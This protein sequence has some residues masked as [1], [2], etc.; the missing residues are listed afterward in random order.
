MGVEANLTWSTF[1]CKRP[2]RHRL[3]DILGV[4]MLEPFTL[5]I[6][7]GSSVRNIIT[8]LA[9]WMV[10][11]VIGCQEQ[12]NPV[13]LPISEQEQ[14]DPEQPPRLPAPVL[15]VSPPSISPLVG[16]KDI[17][18]DD[19]ALLQNL[20]QRHAREGTLPQAVQYQYWVVQ[21]TEQGR[22]DLACWESLSGKSEAAL[23]WLQQAG[24]REGIDTRWAQVDADLE[25]A[26]RDQ[27]WPKLLAYLQRCEKY[28][29][30]V[31][32]KETVLV[33]PK[34]Y[35]G[36]TILPTVLWLHGMGGDPKDMKILF[37][38]LADQHQI[39]FI[40]VSGTIPTG[41][42]RFAWAD[43]VEEDYDQIQQALIEAQRQIRMRPGSVVALGFSQGA[44]V[45][46]E[47]AVRH[48]EI[49]AGAITVSA[50][51]GSPVQLDAVSD[52][53]D[54]IRQGFVI[55]CGSKENEW[56]VRRSNDV[57]EW[58]KNGNAKVLKPDYP[59]HS[60]HSFPEDFDNRLPEWLAFVQK[61]HETSTP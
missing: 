43:V 42:H 31:V 4:M 13:P 29:R 7:S 6:L 33:V 14:D 57:A 38:P 46:I 27:R 52:T 11:F 21:Q 9:A 50:G 40:G 41:K 28:W 10:I 45:A 56:T 61:A 54:L 15:S 59:N 25:N 58:L 37:Q 39:G 32:P 26:R 3:T 30:A 44:I 19:P 1:A 5:R 47:V 17:S 2:Y 8:I 16:G 49:F 55:V 48:P 24:Q 34:N 35:D 23:Y 18:K 12:Q 60:T 36:K 51:T 20:A 22:Y 53:A